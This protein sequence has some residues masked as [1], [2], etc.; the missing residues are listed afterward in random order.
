M[1]E[2]NKSQRVQR[3]AELRWVPIAEMRVSPVAQRELRQQ[4]VDR[5]LA[6]FDIE[7][8][9]NPTVNLRSGIYYVIDGQ[10]RI[11]A[12]RQMGW[13]DQHIQCWCYEGLSEH[14]E[15]ETFLKLQERLTVRA[16]DKFKVGVVAGRQEEREIDAVV[17]GLGLMVSDDKQPGAIGA[18]GTLRRIY[19]RDGAAVLGRTLRIAHEAFGDA[20]LEGAIVDGI[21]LLCSRYNGDLD[22]SQAIERLGSVPKGASGLLA[23]AERLRVRTHAARGHCVAAAAVE[24]INRGRGRHKLAP[25]WFE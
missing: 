12:L 9:G 24:V 7:Q 4:W 20:G 19:Q 3:H 18:V 21:G 14:E 16:L 1:A 22:E 25:W 11:E 23:S 2:P 8:L 10:H 15:A 5:L 13:G 6:D 17:K